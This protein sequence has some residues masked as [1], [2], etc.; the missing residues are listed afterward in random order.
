MT[1]G[2]CRGLPVS[3]T[4]ITRGLRA[5]WVVSGVQAKRV[6]WPLY[7][8]ATEDWNCTA[9]NPYHPRGVYPHRP[10]FPPDGDRLFCDCSIRS[11]VINPVTL[12]Q[13]DW[14]TNR[15]RGFHILATTLTS[16]LTLHQPSAANTM[17]SDN[18]MNNQSRQ[19]NSIPI[20]NASYYWWYL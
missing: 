4:G 2:D 20:Y 8:T 16:L 7:V 15:H 17:L 12:W 11:G 19:W 14:Q 9:P 18:I 10:T 1:G 13:S 3:S 5:V 6:V